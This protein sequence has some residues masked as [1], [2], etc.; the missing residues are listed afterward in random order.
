MPQ[1]APLPQADVWVQ[2]SIVAIVVLAIVIIVGALYRFWRELLAYQAKQEEARAIERKQQDEQRVQ[3]RQLQREWEA[4]QAKE[5]DE[6][7]QAF[8]KQ[9]DAQWLES[10]RRNAAVLE[11]LVERID[12]LTISIN[13]H[14]TFVRA[15]GG[16]ADKPSRRRSS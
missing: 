6:R 4:A 3:D 9:R 5:R 1:D 8:L 10:D 16:N 15:A 7:W 13:S 11:K 12:E 2:F 14:D